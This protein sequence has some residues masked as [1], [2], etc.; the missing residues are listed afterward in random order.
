M[1]LVIPDLI[2]IQPNVSVEKILCRNFPGFMT[3]PG[4]FLYY[5]TFIIVLLQALQLDTQV[6]S[7]IQP[8][9]WPVPVVHAVR[10]WGF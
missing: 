3:F 10:E 9:T 2:R 5:N 8:E 4:L 6:E 7:T 1:F